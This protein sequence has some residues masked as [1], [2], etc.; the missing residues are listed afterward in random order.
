MPGARL[1][2]V[3]TLLARAP[4]LPGGDT[5]SGMELELCLDARGQIEPACGEEPWPVRRFWRDREDWHG[6]L[7]PVGEGWGLRSARGE[8]EPLWE[9]QVRLVRPG[10]YLTLVR[11]GQDEL[12]FRIVNVE[13]L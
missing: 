6:I 12:L 7:V 10:E 4:G 9:L 2:R 11:P 13:A 1:S 3:T 5:R 8:D